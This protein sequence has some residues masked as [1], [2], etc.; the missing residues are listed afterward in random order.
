MQTTEHTPEAIVNSQRV[1]VDTNEAASIL[2]LSPGTMRN[3][4]DGGPIRPV[5]VGNVLRWRLS[6]IKALLGDRRQ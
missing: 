3:W 4:R 1:M 5:K 6:D 2:E